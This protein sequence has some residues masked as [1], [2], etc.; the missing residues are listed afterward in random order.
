MPCCNF[1]RKG[2]LIFGGCEETGIM[3]TTTACYC[4]LCP[5]F[6]GFRWE[7]L[8]GGKGGTSLWVRTSWGRC[9]IKVA[10]AEEK[11][12]VCFFLHRDQI[13]RWK[14]KTSCPANR[15][16][17]KTCSPLTQS[18]DWKGLAKMSPVPNVESI[19]EGWAP[20]KAG[21]P[22]KCCFLSL[23]SKKLLILGRGS[24]GSRSGLCFGRVYFSLWL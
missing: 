11:M 15:L 24:K 22:S 3:A 7:S 16:R 13:H 8:V 14:R 20:R 18:S 10:V 2:W 19:Q 4:W 1:N 17:E 23:W 21:D 6:W 9:G 5:L 12:E